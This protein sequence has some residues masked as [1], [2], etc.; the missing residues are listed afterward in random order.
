V[1]AVSPTSP[2]PERLPVLS[3]RARVLGSAGV[4]IAAAAMA[5]LGFTAERA[6]PAAAHSPVVAPS[7]SSPSASTSSSSGQLT[8]LSLSELRG[9]KPLP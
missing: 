7:P 2:E 9:H 6:V 5:L 8:T 1:A 3:R 4:L